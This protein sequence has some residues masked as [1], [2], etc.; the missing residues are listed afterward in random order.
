M[1]LDI[2]TFLRIA[3]SPGESGQLGDVVRAF[4]WDG[5]S[6]SDVRDFHA[7]YCT[8]RPNA[9]VDPL[10]PG[11]G[12]NPDAAGVLTFYYL[13]SNGDPQGNQTGPG[14]WIRVEPFGAEE[15][16]TMSGPGWSWAEV[17]GA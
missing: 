9:Y 6:L 4:Q 1:A 16:N 17:P 7:M 2:R 11:T 12:G 14:T 15:P 3:L 8:A 5:V 13:D 10:I